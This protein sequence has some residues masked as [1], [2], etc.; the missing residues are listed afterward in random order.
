MQLLFLGRIF[1]DLL[2]FASRYSAAKPITAEQEHLMR[3]D[4]AIEIIRFYRIA[5]SYALQ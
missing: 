5:G 4:I 3:L 1:A 2:D